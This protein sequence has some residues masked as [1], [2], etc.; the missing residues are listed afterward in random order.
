[1]PQSA[2]KYSDTLVSI[3]RAYDA[4]SVATEGAE[5]FFSDFQADFPEVY[6][7]PSEFAAW[8]RG[9]IANAGAMLPALR[10]TIHALVQ[11]ETPSLVI[12]IDDAGDVKVPTEIVELLRPA[13]DEAFFYPAASSLIAETLVL[14]PDA[15]SGAR[16]ILFDGDGFVV[17]ANIHPS[18]IE[19]WF[20][21]IF[22]AMTRDKRFPMYLVPRS[23]GWQAYCLER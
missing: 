19:V 15:P 9:Q 5:W 16:V 12:A 11:Q 21:R 23:Y 17:P 4:A 14:P 13:C 20:T 8:T 1:M 22:R 3:V 6:D 7:Q 2:L 18:V 10:A